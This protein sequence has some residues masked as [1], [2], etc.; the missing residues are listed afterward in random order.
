MNHRFV[1]LAFLEQRAAQ[2]NVDFRAVGCK[3]QRHLV[4]GHRFVHLALLEQRVAE[5]VMGD[6]VVG[7]DLQRLLEMGDRF[8]RLAFLSSASPR[9]LWASA[10]S[11]LICNAVWK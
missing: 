11:G 10:K 7:V 9:L 2:V 8:V 5:V 4:L 1:H 6:R 3:L